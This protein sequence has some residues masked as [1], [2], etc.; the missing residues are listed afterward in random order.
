MSV[1]RLTWSCALALAVVGSGCGSPCD[2]WRGTWQGTFS[3]TIDDQPFN[4]SGTGFQLQVTTTSTTTRLAM[5]DALVPL[6]ATYTLHLLAV[7]LDCTASQLTLKTSQG[8]STFCSVKS[9]TK[10]ED[11]CDFNGALFSTGTSSGTFAAPTSAD[12][13][14][15]FT[16]SGAWTL[17]H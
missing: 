15:S 4:L 6:V 14:P 2:A 11:I 5:I 17:T 10:S 8:R 13:S 16:G 7:E 1:K 3:G 12:Q 9:A